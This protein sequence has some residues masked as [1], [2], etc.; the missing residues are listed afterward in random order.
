MG[1]LL[2]RSDFR[3]RGPA[4]VAHLTGE[5]D[6]SVP[7][8]RR[9]RAHA[10]VGPDHAA[11]ASGRRRLVLARGG[12]DLRSQD[13]GGHLCQVGQPRRVPEPPRHAVDQ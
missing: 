5:H 3:P 6:A 11:S 13:P 10:A 2:R 12:H 9:W 4:G 7:M 8:P 1:W